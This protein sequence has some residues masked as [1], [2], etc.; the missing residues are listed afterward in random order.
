MTE[1]HIS[2]NLILNSS[3][4]KGNIE[5][6]NKVG[7]EDTKVGFVMQKCLKT[8]QA[9]PCQEKELFKQKEEKKVKSQTGDKKKVKV[10]RKLGGRRQKLVPTEEDE[11]SCHGH[12]SCL[13]WIFLKWKI[14][15][16]KKMK[17][18]VGQKDKK[19]ASS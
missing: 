14:M 5:S 13:R 9:V 12:I 1:Q 10:K 2:E 16:A 3:W 17:I 4:G 7:R 18:R 8:F 19:N 6:E 15:G 11:K